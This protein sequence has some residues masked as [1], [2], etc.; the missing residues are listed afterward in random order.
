MLLNVGN[1]LKH[2]VQYMVQY[3]FINMWLANKMVNS[4]TV[5]V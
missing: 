1:G 4:N 5:F 2:P 3:E